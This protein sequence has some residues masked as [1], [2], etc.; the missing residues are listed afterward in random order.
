MDDV[1]AHLIGQNQKIYVDDMIVK[2]F[3]GRNHAEDMEDV[4][5]S[6]RKYDMRL[7]PIKCSFAVPT[8]KTKGF[9]LTRRSIET[10]LDKC[11]LVITVK[12]H[13]NVKQMQQLISR[14]ASLSRFLSC[15]G[16]KSFLFFVSLMKKN[17]LNGP[18]S[19]KRF[20]PR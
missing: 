5:Q 14:L 12:I 18:M 7:N 9:I 15:E 8:S 10:N 6:V 4:L 13:I 11:Q 17:Y 19:V 3:E 20:S 2:T 1:F 16:D